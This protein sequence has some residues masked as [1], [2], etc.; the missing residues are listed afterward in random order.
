MKKENLIHR[1]IESLALFM[2]GIMGA[3]FIIVCLVMANIARYGW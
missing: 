2:L 3:I 1:V